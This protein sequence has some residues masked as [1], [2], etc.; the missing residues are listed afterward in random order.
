[1]AALSLSILVFGANC[2]SPRS[3]GSIGRRCGVVWLAAFLVY[4]SVMIYQEMH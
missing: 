3:G 4:A 1:M 2:R